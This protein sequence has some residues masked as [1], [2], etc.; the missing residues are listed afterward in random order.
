MR[1]Y[2]ARLRAA[3]LR[4]VQVWVPD[5]RTVHF[6]TEAR[7]QSVS[8]SGSAQEREDM[9]FV[10]AVQADNLDLPKT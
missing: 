10:E 4:P 5:T 1:N 3:G 2:R 7:R 8:V 6:A 9:D